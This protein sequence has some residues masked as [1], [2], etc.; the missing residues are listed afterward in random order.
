VA[1]PRRTSSNTKRWHLVE[2]R[3]IF[4]PQR[5][6]LVD[7]EEPPVVDL[8]RRDAPVREPVRLGVEQRIETIERAR[9]PGD[10]VEAAQAG[11]DEQVD[12]GTAGR[13]APPDAA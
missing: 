3:R 12:C 13:S 2:H 5:R 11:F 6:Q 8:F 10:A 1:A 9:L 7:V 4:H